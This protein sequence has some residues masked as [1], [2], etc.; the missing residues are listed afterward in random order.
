MILGSMLSNASSSPLIIPII[1]GV[2]AILVASPIF[3]LPTREEFRPNVNLP[4]AL[5]KFYPLP[6]EALL[7]SYSRGN[8]YLTSGKFPEALRELNRAVELAPTSPDVYMARG[9]ALEK[10]LKWQDAIN[11]YRKANELFKRF[12]LAPDDATALSNIANAETG[13]L[14]WDKALED[15][16]KASKLQPGFLAPQIGRALV[17]YQLGN[18]DEASRFF[19]ELIDDYPAFPDGLAVLA[20]IDYD[21]GDSK[22]AIENWQAALEIDSR[23]SDVN[24][25]RDIRR[26]PPKL[27]DKLVEFMDYMSKTTESKT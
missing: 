21:K 15:F 2:T 18:V 17:Q 1:K 8:S 13:L 4:T 9:I 27:C 26:W 12:P 14:Q 16:S 5:T 6:E 25:I 23:Y 10:V 20:V 3:L 11:D 19:T 24:W 22:N 7:N